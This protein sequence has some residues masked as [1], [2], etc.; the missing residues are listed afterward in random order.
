MAL[1]L[2]P[3]A[4]DT[5]LKGVYRTYASNAKF[6]S[7]ATLPHLSFMSAC[8][9]EMTGLDLA[10]SYQLAFSAIRDLAVLLRNALSMKTADAYKEVYCWQVGRAPRCCHQFAATMMIIIII[11]VV[12]GVTIGQLCLLLCI[13]CWHCLFFASP[14]IISH[15]YWYVWTA[16]AHAKQ[17]PN[18]GL[19]LHPHKRHTPSSSDRSC[20]AVSCPTDCQLLGGVV[21]CA[22]GSRVTTPATAAGVPAGPGVGWCCAAGAYAQILPSQAEDCE[23]H[24]QVRW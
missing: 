17:R 8:M 18:F 14:A 24:Q 7:P 11:D 3:P 15:T 2:P 22:V 20:T 4:L 23:S 10:A 21:P 16:C 1:T 9:V 6:V 19:S 12:F 13:C 5:C